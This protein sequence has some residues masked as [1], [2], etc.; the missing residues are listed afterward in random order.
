MKAAHGP[1][2]LHHIAVA[3]DTRDH[4]DNVSWLME[5]Y[6]LLLLAAAPSIHIRCGGGAW[7]AALSTLREWVLP[8][9]RVPTV[10]VAPSVIRRNSLSCVGNVSVAAMAVWLVGMA[11]E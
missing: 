10:T 2:S 9:G 6:W 3:W 8:G 11:E 7:V 4:E 1:R 5:C